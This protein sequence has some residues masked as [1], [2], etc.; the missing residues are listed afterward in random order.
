MSVEVGSPIFVKKGERFALA[1]IKSGEEVGLL[2]QGDPSTMSDSG[3]LETFYQYMYDLG[4]SR[5]E[6]AKT[7]FCRYD[8]F[9][10]GEE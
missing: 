7:R 8:L 9:D 2:F 1:G 10:F 5:N 6:I 4:A 3:H